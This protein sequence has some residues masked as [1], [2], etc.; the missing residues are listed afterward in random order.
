MDRTGLSKLETAGRDSFQIETTGEKRERETIKVR[1]AVTLESERENAESRPCGCRV[2]VSIWT[3]AESV[4][5]HS[6]QCVNPRVGIGQPQWE[7]T[8]GGE[9]AGDWKKVR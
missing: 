2:G 1:T 7:L 4:D 6:W 8:A 5:L 3:V 9:I